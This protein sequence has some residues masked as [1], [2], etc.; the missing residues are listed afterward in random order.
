ANRES[1]SRPASV[2]V[3]YEAPGPEVVKPKLYVLAV[4]IS[5][6]ANS[7]YDL[8]FA[9]RDAEAFAA[10]WKPQEG[11][12]YAEVHTRVL[13]NDQ[14]SGANIRDGMDWLAQN[15]TQHDVAILFLSGHG[16]H[17]ASNN[18]YLATREIA[19]KRLRATA[20]PYS[21]V[22]R[23][24]QEALHCKILLFVDTCHAGG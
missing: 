10:A 6:Y 1:T 14:A 16:T 9:D 2:A 4:G 5:K 21:D 7:A 12:V 24:I 18:Y 15:V 13:T 19:P 23:L 8:D 22:T 3:S 20:I 17:D 11:P